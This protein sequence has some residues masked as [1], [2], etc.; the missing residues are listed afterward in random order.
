M[1]T[2]SHACRVLTFKSYSASLDAVDLV[3]QAF[4]PPR[5]SSAEYDW[6]NKRFTAVFADVDGAAIEATLEHAGFQF[7]SMTEER[8]LAWFAAG[9]HGD[10]DYA[11]LVDDCLGAAADDCPADHC[12]DEA[13][14][15]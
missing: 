11:R 14:R 4:G 2:S 1:T 3:A 7:T 6:S 5:F 9:F 13:G 12:L 8:E 15:R 10:E